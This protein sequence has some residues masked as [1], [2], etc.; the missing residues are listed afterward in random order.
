MIRSRNWRG[1]NNLRKNIKVKAGI[2]E[3][4]EAGEMR[5]FLFFEQFCWQ[6]RKPSTYDP[7]QDMILH[8]K[9]EEA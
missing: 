8:H 7:Q 6:R 3:I 4:K 2:S 1:E 5:L 9:S